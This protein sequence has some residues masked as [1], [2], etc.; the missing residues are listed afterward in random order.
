MSLGFD[1]SDNYQF[2]ENETAMTYT[3][4]E[5]VKALGGG[6]IPVTVKAGVTKESEY[7]PAT[8][9]LI[10]TINVKATGNCE[11]ITITDTMSGT[12]YAVKH[13]SI[14]CTPDGTAFNVSDKSDYGF[15]ATI[16]SLS[17][18]TA[19]IT[20]RAYLKDASNVGADGTITAGKNTVTVNTADDSNSNDNTATTPDTTFPVTSVLEK[21]G[22]VVEENGTP[23]VD[24]DGNVTIN[25]TIKV[26]N[27]RIIPLNGTPI[28]DIISTNQ[29]YSGTG[30]TVKKTDKNGTTSSSNIAWAN[31]EKTNDSFTYTPSDSTPYLYEISYSTKAEASN[32]Y[33]DF[34]VTNKVNSKGKDTEEKVGVG[35]PEGGKFEIQKDIVNVD[36]DK[37]EISWVITMKIPPAGLPNLVLRDAYPHC[38]DPNDDSKTLYYDSLVPG[39]VNISGLDSDESYKIYEDEDSYKRL[40]IQFYQD[41]SQK[42]VGLKGTGSARTIT[43]NLSTKTNPDWLEYAKNNPTEGRQEQRH[44]NLAEASINGKTIS[45]YARVYLVDPTFKK[46]LEGGLKWA[47]ASDGST[48]PYLDYKLVFTYV[49]EDE[50]TINETL[51]EGFV[52]YKE[53]VGSEDAD[54]YKSEVI[55]GDS[56]NAMTHKSNS[57]VTFEDNNKI[58]VK[59]PKKP[60]GDYYTYY[61]VTYHIIAKDSAAAKALNQRAVDNN[62]SIDLVNTA[63]YKGV[64]YSASIKYTPDIGYY[65]WKSLN[66]EAELS[67]YQNEAKYSININHLGLKL[68]GIYEVSEVASSTTIANY[69]LDT[70]SVTSEN[71]E[72]NVGATK[73]VTLINNY[74]QDKGKLSIKKTVTTDDTNGEVDKKSL[75]STY[76]FAVKNSDGNYIKDTNGTIGDN[77]AFYFTGIAEDATLTINNL[78]VGKYTIEEKDANVDGFALTTTGLGEVSVT[79]NSD[80]TATV[81]NQYTANKKPT[82]DDNDT[83]PPSEDDD[84][85]KKPSDDND[86]TKNPSGDDNS[87]R[88]PVTEQ[89]TTEQ[90][91]TVQPTTAGITTEQP[92]TAPEITTEKKKVSTKKKK[93]NSDDDDDDD[94]G[95][96]KL[97]ITIHDEKTGKAVP[98]AI[99]TVTTPD[100]KSKKYTTDSNGQIKLKKTEAGDY[101]VKVTKVPKGYTV[102]KNKEVD[103]EVEKNKTTTALVKINKDG[104]ITVSSKTTKTAAKTGDTIP[105]KPIT[106]ALIIA[107]FGL[108]ILSFKKKQYN[109]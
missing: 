70:G 17:N 51:P 58:K 65:L 2:S 33:T 101:T 95:K 92:T 46:S 28:K 29:I 84:S 93:N 64:T 50:F 60:D 83:N 15:T 37:G 89:N 69:T 14:K 34:D 32:S 43:V 73:N 82:G 86:D 90:P 106:T 77:T 4:P 1:E 54:V 72:I 103:V 8:G 100:G 11:N 9:E 91:T 105:V 107:V 55:G 71:V 19:T 30:I 36:K 47:N 87:S 85:S 16:G 94:D 99:V 104:D 12:T 3:L 56:P 102:T 42:T 59:V 49:N 26:N 25:W 44:S 57:S 79:K 18:Q 109:R 62:G 68:N 76:Q 24:S 48:L 66:N 88:Q 31:L 74:S 80:A 38:K 7:D 61:E 98:G 21:T 40:K 35:V 23:K 97:I 78:P 108:I 63:E 52:F 39:S 75:P 10:Y 53:A 6:T 13:D 67:D 27:E 96:G 20:Y 45:D 81:N 41:T 5:G 22:S